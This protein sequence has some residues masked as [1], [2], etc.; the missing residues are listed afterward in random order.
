MRCSLIRTLSI[1]ML[2]G[3][4]LLFTGGC[5]KAGPPWPA[6]TESPTGVRWLGAYSH[7][8]DI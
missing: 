2:T 1:L 5:M 4:V 6:I 3:A 7:T 8:I